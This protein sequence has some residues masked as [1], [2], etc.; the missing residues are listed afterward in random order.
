MYE[1]KHLIRKSSSSFLKR[2]LQLVLSI[3]IFSCI[4]CY[5][6]G[7]SFFPHSFNV[8]FS[9]FLFSFL[10]HTLER[11][12][13]FLICNGILVFLAKTSI[14][15]S[16]S[17]SCVGKKNLPASELYSEVK[18]PVRDVGEEAIVEARTESNSLE[19]AALAAEEELDQQEKEKEQGY[20]LREEE[21]EEEE[22]REKE[23]LRAEGED[24]EERSVTVEEE[25]NRKVLEAT[26]GASTEYTQIST[27][28]LNKRIEDF[29]RKMKEE[30]RIEAQR[31]LITV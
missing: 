11:K 8:Y 10:T 3:S 23:A 31:Q 20:L 27:D 4:L 17:S 12:Y 18:A 22:E 19:N 25:E 14:A 30:I 1:Y 13:M 6:S 16:S 15:C 5:S 7:F 21:E 24:E 2:T 9:T 28:E 26:E 29:I